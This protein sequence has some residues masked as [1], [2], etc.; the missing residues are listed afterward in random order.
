MTNKTQKNRKSNSEIIDVGDVFRGFSDVYYR[1]R[2]WKDLVKGATVASDYADDVFAKFANGI[3]S[4]CGEVFFTADVFDVLV[5]TPDGQTWECIAKSQAPDGT[6][7]AVT[8][9]CGY[10]IETLKSLLADYQPVS[11]SELVSAAWRRL[12]FG[13]RLRIRSRIRMLRRSLTSAFHK[14]QLAWLPRV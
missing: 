5:V 12:F 3:H 10:H 4:K 9:P 2:N 13:T 8:R 7:R 1:T 6:W 11:E 14:L